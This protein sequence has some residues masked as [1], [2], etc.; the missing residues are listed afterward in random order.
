MCFG[1]IEREG[2]PDPSD[3]IMGIREHRRRDTHHRPSCLAHPL[4]PVDVAEPPASRPAMFVAL[5]FDGDPCFRISHVAVESELVAD[6]DG[7]VNRRL[8]KS[9]A[10]ENEPGTCLLHGR[11]H[12]T[13][14]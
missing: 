1:T 7:H 2:P 13:R 8:G 12:R 14:A 9:S 3:E 6:I 5:V 4:M 11:P 10:H